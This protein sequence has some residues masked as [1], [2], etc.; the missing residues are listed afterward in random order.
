M[1]KN[2]KCLTIKNI[3]KQFM[4]KMKV[5]LDV[6]LFQ[7]QQRL[8]ENYRLAEMF[9]LSVQKI[10]QRLLHF[11]PSTLL[12]TRFQASTGILDV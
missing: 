6:C 4:E 3:V 8:T 12:T 11:S 10:L 5:N 9:Y 1:F 2:E 7:S